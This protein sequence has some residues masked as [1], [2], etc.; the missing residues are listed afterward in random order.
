MV[1]LLINL[2]ILSFLR[3]KVNNHNLQKI[4]FDDKNILAYKGLL[5]S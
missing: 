5:S 3:A 2:F 1:F 4:G